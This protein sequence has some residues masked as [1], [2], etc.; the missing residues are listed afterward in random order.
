MCWPDS[1]DRILEAMQKRKLP[2]EMRKDKGLYEKAGQADFLTPGPFGV[3]ETDG[4]SVRYLYIN[5][6]YLSIL[7]MLGGH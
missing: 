5:P 4:E 6:E 1:Y 3:L 7:K 2:V